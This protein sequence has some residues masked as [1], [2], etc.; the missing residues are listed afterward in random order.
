[1]WGCKRQ[2]YEKKPAKI[3]IDLYRIPIYNTRMIRNFKTKTAQDIFNGVMSASARKIPG[4]LHDKAQRLLDQINA[5]TKIETLRI[6]P[7]N[8]LEKLK[9]TL[10]NFW[11]VRINK[12]WRVIFTWRDGE[13]CDVDIV[14][15]H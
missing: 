14:D 2:D 7:G 13:A 4:T 12:Q 5:A 15:Y 11:S 8:Q 6:P 9:G 3:K 10:K 1:M